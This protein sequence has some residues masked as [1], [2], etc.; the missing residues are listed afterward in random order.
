MANN[1]DIPLNPAERQ[2]LQ[3]RFPRAGYWFGMLD[4]HP[5]IHPVLDQLENIANPYQ[6]ILQE[7]PALD[8]P[9]PP[10]HFNPGIAG[11]YGNYNHFPPPPPAMYYPQMGPPALPAPSHYRDHAAPHAAPPPR[12]PARGKSPSFTDAI[13]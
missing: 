6:Y 1:H 12:A 7:P 2:E 3:R 9:A 8:A 10:A 11:M 4:R 5:D 13:P